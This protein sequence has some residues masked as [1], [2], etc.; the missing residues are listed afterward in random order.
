[1][2]SVDTVIEP[3]RLMGVQLAAFLPRLAVGLLI[4][5]AGW[6]LAKAARFAAARALRAVNFN[7]LSERAGLDGFLR[8]GGID[9]DTSAIFG[10]IAYWAVLLM[11]LAASFNAM[12]FP[13]LSD[14]LT[15]IVL[16]MPR[17]AVALL[18]LT[19]G[20]Y[21]ARFV[22]QAVTRYC[23]DSGISDAAV[24]GVTAH[25]AV[26][27]FVGLIVVDQTGIGGD[28]LRLSFLI[29]LGGMVLALALAFGIG[30]AKF[31]GRLLDRW[32]PAER[33]DERP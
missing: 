5:V 11:A 20:L 23:R 6:L 29:V 1:M 26:V 21:F 25:Y 31:A 4:V 10:W 28:V 33:P 16:F 27:V 15:R 30:G 19:F 32:W 18:I 7:V 8:Q 13:Y 24:L 3:L 12:N 2:D 9:S 14:F 17:L 22:G